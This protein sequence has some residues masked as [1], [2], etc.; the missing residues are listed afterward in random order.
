M[1]LPGVLRLAKVVLV[2]QVVV[3]A[4]VGQVGVF[5]LVLD[6]IAAAVV[7][8]VDICSSSW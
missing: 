6:H 4:V 2:R 5:I 8:I 1:M 7:V 3:V